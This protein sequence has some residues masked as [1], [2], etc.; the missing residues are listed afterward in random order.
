LKYVQAFWI[1]SK[2]F[3]YFRRRGSPRV[4]L[5]GLPG[6]AV[7]MRA[8]EDA[9]AAQPVAIG[10]AWRS[11]PGSVSAA[12]AEYYTSQAF[13]ALSGSTRPNG[14]PLWRAFVGGSAT[15][16]WR[17][18]RKNSSSR[19]SIRCRRIPRRPF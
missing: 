4:R 6:S 10:K 8:Y 13:R 5:P 16:P 7:F 11:K 3:Y 12:L 1:G 19:C 14:D 2:R 18:C 9:L 15:G 17:R